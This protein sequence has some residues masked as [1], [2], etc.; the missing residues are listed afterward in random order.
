MSANLSSCKVLRVALPD[1]TQNTIAVS[2]FAA[3]GCTIR[4]ITVEVTTT[5]TNVTIQDGNGTNLLSAANAPTNAAGGFAIALT[6]TAANLSLLGEDSIVLN[7]TGASVLAVNIF[8]GDLSPAT[9]PV[10]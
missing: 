5:G 6:A 10:T 8:F 3:Q 9:I 7:P 1:A 4:G 2:G